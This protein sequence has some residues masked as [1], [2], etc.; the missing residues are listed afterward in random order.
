MARIRAPR[1]PGRSGPPTPC[2]RRSPSAV[3]VVVHLVRDKG[4]RRLASIGT[5][6]RGFGETEVLPAVAFDAEGR[7]S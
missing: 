4:K 2:T 6:D 7:A 1:R 3:Q 5:L